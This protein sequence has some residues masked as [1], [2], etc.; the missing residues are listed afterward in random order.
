M[1]DTTATLISVVGGPG[2]HPLE[3]LRHPDRRHPS[4]IFPDQPVQVWAHHLQLALPPG[5][6]HHRDP[7]LGGELRDRLPEPQPNPLQNRRR[8]NRKT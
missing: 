7:L 5:E 3:L 8:R 6:A 2:E 4:P 1:R